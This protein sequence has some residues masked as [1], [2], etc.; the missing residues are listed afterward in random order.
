[1]PP[2]VFI[3]PAK[4]NGSNN[5]T[6]LIKSSDY[7]TK[8]ESEANQLIK[9]SINA[10]ISETQRK[11]KYV[12]NG[13]VLIILAAVLIILTACGSDIPIEGTRLPYSR[14]VF[15]LDAEYNMTVL[16]VFDEEVPDVEFVKP[17]GTILVTESL[18]QRPGGNFIQFFFPQAAPG[19]WTMNYDALTNTEITTPYSVYM[20]QIFIYGFEV[21][22]RSRE[23]ISL[24]FGISADEDWLVYYEI[25]VEFTAPDNST[26]DEVL[27]ASGTDMLNQ[28][29]ERQLDI[30]E[31][32]GRGGFLIRLFVT[33]Q[34]GQAAIH[35]TAWLDL[36][37]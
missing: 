11:T 26:T 33:K 1:M 14:E 10:S 32:D 12:V 18:R 16:V 36:R 25:Y 34:H 27:L 3:L 15:S 6:M 23:Q 37:H 35:D 4:H 17:D 21:I 24:A 20:E 29:I 19:T 9:Q 28:I 2:A 8:I 5:A 13:V 7:S 30:T 22:E 31:L